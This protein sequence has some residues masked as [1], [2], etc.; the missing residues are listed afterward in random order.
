MEIPFS[1]SS[2]DQRTT[3]SLTCRALLHLL[4]FVVGFVLR[5]GSTALLYYC[6]ACYLLPGQE[7]H[8]EQGSEFSFYSF[9]IAV[10]VLSRLTLKF[11]ET[12][13]K[14]LGNKIFFGKLIYLYFMVQFFSPH[15]QQLL[16][17]K[18]SLHLC[19]Q[20][21]RVHCS[22]FLFHRFP[23][24]LPE[25]NDIVLISET[26]LA[27]S[28]VRSHIPGWFF[29]QTCRALLSSWRWVVV[30]AGL[31]CH[32]RH[33]PHLHQAS[34]S[35]WML[36]S[37]SQLHCDLLEASAG[38]ESTCITGC[39]AVKAAAS[40]LGSHG[41]ALMLVDA[42]GVLLSSA[43]LGTSAFCTS[44]YKLRHPLNHEGQQK[45]RCKKLNFSV[46]RRQMSLRM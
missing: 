16:W 9:P 32:Q 27:G 46:I 24:A 28:S 4:G 14:V 42:F 29:L 33:K 3:A 41:V 30:S 36:Q 23:N 19:F 20:K 44:L 34:P 45:M 22:F 31:P 43:V 12:R 10:L 38:K 15:C 35:L 2:R 7:A 18:Q 26:C 5:Q 13:I 25:P 37:S 6:L 40:E 21:Q 11:G 8:C 1:L 39:P 17:K